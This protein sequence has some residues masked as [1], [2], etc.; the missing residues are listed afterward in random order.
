MTDQVGGGLH[1]HSM[2]RIAALVL[3]SIGVLGCQPDAPRRSASSAPAPSSSPAASSSAAVPAA[4]PFDPV[5][6]GRAAVVLRVE[7]IAQL[8][9]DKYGWDEVAPLEVL[10]NDTSHAFD[11]N[12]RVAHY[13]WKPGVPAGISTIYLE[14]YGGSSSNRWRLLEAD[15]SVGVSHAA[16]PG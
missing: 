13:S 11:E 6:A 2:K 9:A 15:G 1:G 4:G 10:K 3:V 5:R 12:F 14:P 8:G 7:R 16:G